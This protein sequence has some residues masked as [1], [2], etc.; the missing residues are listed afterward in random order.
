MQSLTQS[1]NKTLIKF[2]SG[3]GAFAKPDSKFIDG[4]D[5]EQLKKLSNN[6]E[7]FNLTKVGKELNF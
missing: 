7:L 1:E 4:V 5:A 6:V 2:F 3:L